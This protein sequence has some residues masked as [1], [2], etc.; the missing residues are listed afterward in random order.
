LLSELAC[1]TAQHQHTRARLCAQLDDADEMGAEHVRAIWTQHR[2]LQ[3]ADQ[4]LKRSEEDLE[5]LQEMHQAMCQQLKEE[6]EV[7]GLN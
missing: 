1:V 7:C 6:I 2:Q 5:A 3:D 4:A